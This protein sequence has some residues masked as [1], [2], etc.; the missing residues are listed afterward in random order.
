MAADTKERILDVAQRLFSQKGY[1]VAV[2]VGGEEICR[3]TGLC[4]L[5]ILEPW[6]PPAARL[7]AAAGS[8]DLD[9]VG[10]EVGQQLARPRSGEHATQI[11]DFQS[12]EGSAQGLRAGSNE[13]ASLPKVKPGQPFGWPGG[14]ARR[15]RIA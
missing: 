11:D 9:D 1:E 14:S 5:S 2:A 7:V 6:R 3:V 8:F 12:V 4:A 13:C 15:L 10:A